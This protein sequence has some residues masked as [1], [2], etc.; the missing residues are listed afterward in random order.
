VDRV[1]IHVDAIAAGEQV[2]LVDDLV[3][4][5]GTSL[6]AINLIQKLGGTVLAC[7]FV[8][9]LPDLKGPQRLRDCGLDVVT[10]CAFEGD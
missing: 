6:A 9:D 10:L 3:A 1:E 4:T 8:V 2:L 5:G 7:A